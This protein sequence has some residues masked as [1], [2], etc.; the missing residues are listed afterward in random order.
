[1]NEVPSPAG[2]IHHHQQQFHLRAS[3]LCEKSFHQ[4]ACL[5]IHYIH[6]HHPT[7]MKPTLFTSMF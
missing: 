3:L 1:M 2:G 5:F 6:L 7:E 4:P